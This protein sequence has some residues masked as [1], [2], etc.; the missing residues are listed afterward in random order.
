[1]R[2]YGK[3]F[4]QIAGRE[5][6]DRLPEI[7]QDA[8]LLEE[9]GRDFSVSVEALEDVQVDRLVL[10]AEGIRKTAAEGEL[11]EE[12]GLAAL[13]KAAG[14]VAGARLLALEAT[15]GKCALAGGVAAA[16]ALA[17]MPRPRRGLQLVGLH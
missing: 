17:A 1:M 7:A 8:L 13:E 3:F 9:L 4:R 12:P 10:D 2:V 14:F 6:L 11:L 15:S 16:D 5:H